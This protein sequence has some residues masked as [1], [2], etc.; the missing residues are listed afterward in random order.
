MADTSR[1][2]G[3]AGLFAIPAKRKNIFTSKFIPK[4]KMV[5]DTENLAPV[6]TLATLPPEHNFGPEQPARS[7]VLP[8]KGLSANDADTLFGALFPGLMAT[9][10]PAVV[11]PGLPEPVM[12]EVPLVKQAPIP[13]QKHEAAEPR[14]RNSLFQRRGPKPRPEPR[15]PAVVEEVKVALEAEEESVRRKTPVASIK[16][17]GPRTRNSLFSRRQKPGRPVER[18]EPGIRN[19]LTTTEPATPTT[20]QPPPLEEDVDEVTP[21]QNL[22]VPRSRFRPRPR[23]T[24]VRESTSEA[25]ATLVTAAPNP[26]T[27][28]EF[29]S[30]QHR[31]SSV[32]TSEPSRPTTTTALPVSKRKGFRSFL[33]SRSRSPGNGGRQSPAG[34]PRLP[35]PEPRIPAGDRSPVPAPLNLPLEPTPALPGPR[36]GHQTQRLLDLAVTDFLPT[37]PPTT[38]APTTNAPEVVTTSEPVTMPRKPTPPQIPAAPLPRINLDSPTANFAAIPRPQAVV[39]AFLQPSTPSRSPSFPQ[40]P[41]PRARQLVPSPDSNVA[42]VPTSILP[43]AQSFTTVQTSR[44]RGSSLRHSSSLP[45]AARVAAAQTELVRSSRGRLDDSGENKHKVVMAARSQLKPFLPKA[46]N[47]GDAL[48]KLR[49][50]IE[51]LQSLNRHRGRG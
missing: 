46:E 31:F 16:S 51:S 5:G 4:V 48:E 30:T 34:G 11:H 37:P 45:A 33:K 24:S 26:S 42:A 28:I 38:S 43:R 47:E 17:T 41:A 1:P 19:L 23:P 20:S 10:P 15:K 36:P 35:K 50:K 7:P 32:A 21:R 49:A 13:V 2:S 44:N 8:E 12:L 40:P 6:P 25:A 18:V 27:P 3:R 9:K 22:F 29:T 14:S 39:P